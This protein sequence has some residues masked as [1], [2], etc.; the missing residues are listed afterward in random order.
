MSYP[1]RRS[2]L[3]PWSRIL[4]R[5]KGLRGESGNA[6]LELAFIISFLGIPLL[7][8]TAQMGSL[9]Y[10]SIEVTNAA[11]AGAMYGMMAPSFAA[12]TAG[13]TTAALNDAPDFTSTTMTVTVNY[14]WACSSTISGPYPITEYN[15]QA[16]AQAV[17]PDWPSVNHDVP[18]IQVQTS[19]TITPLIHCPGL[20][21][22][23]TL[24][25]TAVQEVQQ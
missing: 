6:L 19:A 4:V 8:G 11:N 7:L 2:L 13:I 15:T 24:N 9:I 21:N 3:N 22:T 18:F 17:C 16:A 23:S 5:C 10:Y 1:H 25:A 12:N 20:A 14:Y